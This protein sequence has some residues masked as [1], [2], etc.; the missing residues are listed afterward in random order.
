MVTELG[1]TFQLLENLLDVSSLKH[2][3]TAN[4]IAN[5]NTPGYKKM[6]VD[7]EDQ[8]KKAMK[9]N[10]SGAFASFQPKVVISKIEEDA[11]MRK[12]GNTV[13]ME[14]EFAGLLKNTGSYKIYSQLLSKKFDLVR[15]AIQGSRT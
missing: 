8:L 14:K 11:S 1:K 10:S 7:F 15:E 4:N 2:K 9:S 6:E 12:D 5:I 13:D 3:V